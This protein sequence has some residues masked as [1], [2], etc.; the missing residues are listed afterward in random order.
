M[1][2]KNPGFFG[3]INQF[4]VP[5]IVGAAQQGIDAIPAFNPV[6]RYG[7]GID[8]RFVPGVVANLLTFSF[9]PLL[10]YDFAT[11]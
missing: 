1:T 3:M 6:T 11:R 10:P 4:S 2:G 7:V 9:L 5:I 8:L